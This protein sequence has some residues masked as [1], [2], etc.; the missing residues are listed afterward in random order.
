VA[1]TINRLV[2]EEDSLKKLLS[3]MIDIIGAKNGSI[4]VIEESSGQ[5]KVLAA[6]GSKDSQPSQPCFP[7]GLGVAGWVARE[8]KPLII[9]DVNTSERFY[10]DEK[11]NGHIRA[12]LCLPLVIE[13]QTI[14]VL[15]VS[16]DRP[17]AFSLNTERIL[18][19][20]AGQVAIAIANSE[21]WRKQK[22]KEETLQQTNQKLQE[23][24]KQLEQANN[25]LLKTQKLEAIK[26]LA[27]S[28][29]HE[30]NNPLTT[31]YS[32]MQLLEGR[33]NDQDDASRES[34]QK[35]RESC[36]QI[37][38]IV[39]KL[40]NIHDLVLTKY[41]GDQNM[42]DIEKSYLEDQSGKEDKDSGEPKGP[43]ARG[44]PPVC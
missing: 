13:N 36:K 3:K 1:D 22:L 38:D 31:I 28:M 33:I 39:Y 15:N 2:L 5:L 34:L 37:N 25:R 40:S 4:M 17:D 16:S 21:S 8:S 12:L 35:V 14:G 27:I 42:I 26:E 6:S 24:Q 7:I 11:T 29:H 18:H 20:I 23:T 43:V 19:I 10:R 32:C 9:S 44:L 41:V 30:I